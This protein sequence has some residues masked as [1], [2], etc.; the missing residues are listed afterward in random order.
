MKKP[1]QYHA[2]KLGDIWALYPNVSNKLKLTKTSYGYLQFGL[3]GKSI[4]AHRFIWE[5]FNGPIPK[6]LQINHINGLKTDNRLKNLELVTPKENMEHAFKIG[7]AKPVRHKLNIEQVREIRLLSFTL[8]A[9]K[10]S[11]LYNISSTQVYNIIHH[12]QWS[13]V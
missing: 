13:S 6:G 2:T 4:R 1:I 12:L 9:I 8:S 5:Y 3:Y 7:L 10:I 11:K